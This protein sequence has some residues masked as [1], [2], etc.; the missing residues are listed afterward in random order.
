M[1]QRDKKTEKK[2]ED[3]TPIIDGDARPDKNVE[4]N[5]KERGPATKKTHDERKFTDSRS[6]DKNSMEDYKDAK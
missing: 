1:N 3:V 2:K 5:N 4:P 6:G